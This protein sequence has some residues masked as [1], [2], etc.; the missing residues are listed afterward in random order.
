MAS[1]NFRNFTPLS[2]RFARARNQRRAALGLAPVQ[3]LNAREKAAGSEKPK[4]QRVA[5]AARS[6]L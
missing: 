3:H 1:G 4:A 2:A 6:R 5:I